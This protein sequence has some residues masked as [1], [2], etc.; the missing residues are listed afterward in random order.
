ML[1]IA[2]CKCVTVISE[3]K[4]KK[5]LTAVDEMQIG[6]THYKEGGANQHWNY[7]L[8][9]GIPYL[10]AMAIKYLTRWRKKGGH[11]D[12]RKAYHFVLKLAET[13]GVELQVEPAQT[14]DEAAAS[15]VN[16]GGSSEKMDGR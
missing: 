2:A 10:E 8:A 15:Y 7:V 14:T 11:T 16:Q 1:D 9:N 6:G 5:Q 4:A 3:T 12:I 13:E